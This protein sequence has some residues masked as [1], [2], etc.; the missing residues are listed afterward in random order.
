MLG[1]N[2]DTWFV[3]PEKCSQLLS[4]WKDRGD[5]F[6][7]SSKDDLDLIEIWHGSRFRE[8]SYFWDPNKI[9]LLL[10]HCPHCEEMFLTCPFAMKGDPRYQAILIHIDGWN[11]H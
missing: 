4:H 1:L 3:C 7:V 5:W 6:N 10:C 9:T 11:P 2:F 8:L